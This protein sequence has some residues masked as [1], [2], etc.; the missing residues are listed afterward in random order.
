MRKYLL[1]FLLSI[2]VTNFSQT[3]TFCEGV[4]EKGVP[5]KEATTF[6]IPKQGGYFYFLVKLPY[7]ISCEEVYF[8]IY[9]LDASYDPNEFNMEGDGETYETTI[10]LTTKPDWAWFY[11]QVTFYKT[12]YYRIY[13]KDCT[14]SILASSVVRINW[15]K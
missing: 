11:K 13:V 8:E 10:S 5:I 4:T 6:N 1:L 3:L 15:K 9:G 12:G 14:D 7:T 2:V